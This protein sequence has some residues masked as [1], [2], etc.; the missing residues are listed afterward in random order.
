MLRVNLSPRQFLS[1][2]LLLS[3]V[4]ALEGAQLPPKH[5]DLEIIELVMLANNVTTPAT[6]RELR[7]LGVA[8]A[9][10]DFG[11][12][13]SSLSYLRQFPFDKIKIDQSFVPRARVQFRIGL[14]CPAHRVSW[15]RP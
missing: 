12:G 15:R 9:M 10:D 3:I 11:T 2:R 8:I 4:S 5:L 14:D 1:G 7:K 6:L 13:Y